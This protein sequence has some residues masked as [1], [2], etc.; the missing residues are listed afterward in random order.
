MV[1]GRVL[2]R[3]VDEID[4]GQEREQELRAIALSETLQRIR[5]D[6]EMAPPAASRDCADC[7]EPIDPRR[8]RAYASARRCTQCQNRAERHGF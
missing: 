3:A 8:L 5:R 4:R 7:L 6:L 2:G 1:C